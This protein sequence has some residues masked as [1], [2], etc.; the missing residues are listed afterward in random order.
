M[1]APG[2]HSRRNLRTQQRQ[3]VCKLKQRLQCLDL[4]HEQRK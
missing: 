1:V 2:S 3:E 4:D